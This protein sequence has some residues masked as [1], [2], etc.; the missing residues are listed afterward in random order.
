MRVKSLLIVLN[1]LDYYLAFIN[2]VA[3]AHN[4]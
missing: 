4:K 1:Y 2:Q 3:L